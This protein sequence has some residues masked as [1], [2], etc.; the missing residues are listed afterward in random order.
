VKGCFSFTP[1]PT[2]SSLCSY[3]SISHRCTRV[4]NPGEG[5]PDVFAKIP[6]IS[7]FISFLFTIVLKFACGEG[8]SPPHPPPPPPPPPLHLWFKFRFYNVILTYEMLMHPSFI[9]KNSNFY[10]IRD[11]SI[12]GPLKINCH[13]RYQYHCEYWFLLQ[14]NFHCNPTFFSMKEHCIGNCPLFL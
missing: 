6:P 13:A 8:P 9:F 14:S 7:D 12:P 2:S 4:E 3:V 5:V 1:S 10:W 11:F